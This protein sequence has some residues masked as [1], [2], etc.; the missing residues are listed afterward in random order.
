MRVPPS[1]RDSAVTETR[2]S[3]RMSGVGPEVAALASQW[4][5]RSASAC[6][7]VR[8]SAGQ[9]VPTLGRRLRPVGVPSTVALSQSFATLPVGSLPP[10]SWAN[11]TLLTESPLCAAPFARAATAREG[12]HILQP[13]DASLLGSQP[14]RHPEGRPAR[15]SSTIRRQESSLGKRP[16][17]GQRGASE[18][19]AGAT[20]LSPRSTNSPTSRIFRRLTPRANPLCRLQ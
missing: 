14:A 13:R 4:V 8:R 19:R 11:A 20:T 6:K 1:S 12:A 17:D 15:H 2:P 5:L 3:A 10:T 7:S 18:S 9:S 16:W